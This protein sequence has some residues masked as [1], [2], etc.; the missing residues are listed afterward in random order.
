M[1]GLA[2][3][4]DGDRLIAGDF[5]VSTATAWDVGPS[6]DAE[7]RNVPDP[8]GVLGGPTFGP[9]GRLFVP[10]EG[11]S[12][13]IW[14]AEGGR[15]ARLERTG[16]KDA[17]SRPGAEDV[18]V[19]EDGSTVATGQSPAGSTVWDMGT[20][21]ELFS[22]AKQWRDR[23]ALSPDGHHIAFAGDDGMFV[24]TRE[25]EI[26]QTLP[27]D[28][29]FTFRDPAFSPDGRT[30]VAM[31]TPLGRAP[32]SDLH[33]IAWDWE[34]NTTRSWESSGSGHRPDFSP[35]G[36]RVAIA[37]VGAPSRVL[38]VAS[39]EVLF[40]LEGANAG[41]A[42]VAYSPDGTRIAT[43]GL[44]GSAIVWD[45]SDGALL[46]RLPRLDEEMVGVD[47]SPDGS[48][49][50]T[51][52]RGETAVRIWTLDVAELREIAESKIVRELTDAE[53]REHLHREC[54]GG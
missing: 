10:A 11:G 19:S 26:V 2:S 15:P 51:G 5:Y 41:V 30:V 8:A 7:V 37:E 9:D 1:Y 28:R 44:D 35:D 21:T 47:F 27:A 39:G 16:S 36:T 25:G 48:R 24:R 54:A 34:E 49:L 50:V 23:P 4:G 46:L 52:S 6:G 38:D 22:T 18:A 45:A 32:V 31:T 14:D 12:V 33:A 43:A 42:D 53:C 29:D 3:S 17:S 40:E 20:G 13:A